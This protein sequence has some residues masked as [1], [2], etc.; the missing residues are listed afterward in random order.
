MA[1]A[2]LESSCFIGAMNAPP[3]LPASTVVEAAAAEEENKD[4][5]DQDGLHGAV[6]LSTR[7]AMDETALGAF[8]P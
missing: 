7:H 4:E 6:S 1:S 8:P 2:K 3:H 5:D